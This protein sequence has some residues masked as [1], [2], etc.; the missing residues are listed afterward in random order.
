M[1]G[2][3]RALSFLE[4]FGPLPTI[5]RRTSPLWLAAFETRQGKAYDLPPGPI[6][7][8]IS[9]AHEETVDPKEA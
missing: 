1:S 7:A 2:K 3:V 4:E 8:G 9:V 5:F 6:S